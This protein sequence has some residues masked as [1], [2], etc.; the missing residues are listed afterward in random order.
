M[1]LFPSPGCQRVDQ[2]NR[3]GEVG[4]FRRRG[5]NHEHDV[6]AEHLRRNA[7]LDGAGSHQAEQLRLQSRHLVVGDYSNRIGKRFAVGFS[8]KTGFRHLFVAWEQVLE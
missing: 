6:E 1:C 5:S 7:L 2:R 8:G 3:R 4:R